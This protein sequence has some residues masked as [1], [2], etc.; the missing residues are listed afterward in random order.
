MSQTLFTIGYESAPQ[1]AVIDRLK[2][3]GVELLIDVRAVA[4]SRRAGFSKSVL[5]ASLEAEGIGYAHLRDLGTPKDGRLAVRAGRPK[6]ML[7]IFAR[8]MGGEA[9]RAALETAV[10]DA[11]GRRACL[12]CYEADWRCCHRAVLADMIAPRIGAD[13]IHLTVERAADRAVAV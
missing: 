7:E 2:A 9:A 13:T 12:L 5:A 6:D 3:A 4:A 8:H 1:G 10:S 11:R